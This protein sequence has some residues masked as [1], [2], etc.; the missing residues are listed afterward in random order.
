M[1]FNEPGSSLASSTRVKTLTSRTRADN[2]RF[3]ETPEQVD[4]FLLEVIQPIA[5]WSWLKRSATR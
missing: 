3:F 4:E 1:G 5:L 2:A